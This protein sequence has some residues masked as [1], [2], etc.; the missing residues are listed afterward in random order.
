MIVLVD[1]DGTE[2]QTSANEWKLEDNEDNTE[3][4]SGD[5][6]DDFTTRLRITEDLQT[7]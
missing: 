2:V 3:S 5:D 4:P 6:D 1:G 7:S